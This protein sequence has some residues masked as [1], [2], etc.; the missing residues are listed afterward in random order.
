MVEEGIEQVLPRAEKAGVVLGLEPLH[1]MLA[2]N[3]SI[4][5]TMSQA[6]DLLDK[7]ISPYFQVTVDAFHTWWDPE[8]YNQIRRAKGRIC[9]FHVNDWVEMKYGVNNSRGM[10]GDGMIPLRKI[11]QSI[12]EAGYFG[13]IEIEIFN[14]ELWHMPCEELLRICVERY[15]QYV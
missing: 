15:M 8:L 5:V 3:K 10:I 4:V 12:E 14:E 2:A 11:R 1:P 9:G 7:F 13:P 6:M